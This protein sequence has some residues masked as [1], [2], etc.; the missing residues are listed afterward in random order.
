MEGRGKVSH[1][2]PKWA[3]SARTDAMDA[4]EALA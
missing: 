1:K 4:H 2:S 3:Q